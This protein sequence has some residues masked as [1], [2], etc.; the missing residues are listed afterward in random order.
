MLLQRQQSLWTHLPIIVECC[1]TAA[2]RRRSRMVHSPMAGVWR[3]PPGAGNETGLPSSRGTGA[4]AFQVHLLRC[5]EVE[6]SSGGEESNATWRKL[7]GA[8]SL[9]WQRCLPSLPAPSTD[10]S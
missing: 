3:H 7:S 2:S 5:T 6:K 9:S 8:S 1:C 4:G 10:S